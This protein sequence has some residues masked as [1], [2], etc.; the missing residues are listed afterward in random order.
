MHDYLRLK[1][2]AGNRVSQTI[3][4]PIMIFDYFELQDGF[5]ALAIILVFGVMFYAWG[6]MTVLLLLV[7]GAAPVIRRRNNKGIFLH[8]PYRQFGVSLPGLVNP[9]NARRYSD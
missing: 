6:M 8:W 7:L 2:E 9:G 4:S 1:R 3:D 5:A